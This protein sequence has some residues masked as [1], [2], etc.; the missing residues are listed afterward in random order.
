MFNQ[1]QNEIQTPQ[2]PSAT[3]PSAPIFSEL[4]PKKKKKGLLVFLI[5]MVAVII[6]GGG[7][8][9]AYFVYM[10]N[11]A[12]NPKI[13][14][15]DAIKNIGNAQTLST[16]T[17]LDIFFT[18]NMDYKQSA[19]FSATMDTYS[20]LNKDVKISIGTN[21]YTFKKPEYLETSGSFTI[22]IPK[23]AGI[24]FMDQAD[25][26]PK[27]S[28]I[29]KN[30]G[31]AFL[32]IENIP[33][34]PFFNLDSIHGKWIK[35]DA[36]E[37]EEKYG[38]KITDIENS[39]GSY[40]FDKILALYG[41][42]DF[43]I[44]K[45]LGIE[46]RNNQKVRHF[47]IT[48]DKNKLK[49]FILEAMD[50][51]KKQNPETQIPASYDIKEIEKSLDQFLSL[52]TVSGD[53]WIAKDSGNFTEMSYTIRIDI[54]E[55]IQ[56][57]GTEPSGDVGQKVGTMD[58]NVKILYNN[59]NSQVLIE[60]PA[61]FVT[62]DYVMNALI[63]QGSTLG[64]NSIALDSDNDALSDTDE[65]IYGTDPSNPDSDGD[66]YRDGDEVNGGYNPAGSGKLPILIK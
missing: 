32:K 30:K 36:K 52:V 51:S 20:F 5:V 63:P 3:P 56:K 49:A 29:N 26:N 61:N 25:I 54:P 16:Q 58:L 55:N 39:A 12:V 13:I 1:P 4:E 6:L 28:F 44:L 14:L 50:Y 48:I 34:I 18:P 57:I 35:L 42:N 19:D 46:D 17:S 65:A 66:G 64:D 33:A 37:L 53:A 23:E 9:F 62:I 38:L 24:P 31:V 41:K 27:I 2:A 43:L 11:T 7:G 10:Q 40:Q 8:A 47:L 22:A 59:Y 45:N 21:F 60:E 15:F